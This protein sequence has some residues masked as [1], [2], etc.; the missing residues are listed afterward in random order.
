M[1]P[2]AGIV[3]R[4]RLSMAVRRFDSQGYNEQGDAQNDPNHSLDVGRMIG[5]ESEDEGRRRGMMEV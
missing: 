1:A 2:T 5:E 4:S 3:S